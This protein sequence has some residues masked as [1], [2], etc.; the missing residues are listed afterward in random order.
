MPGFVGHLK[1]F[2]FAATAADCPSPGVF[3]GSNL[4]QLWDAGPKL[5]DRLWPAPAA[6][7]ACARARRSYTTCLA[8]HAG[9]D[10]SRF[11]TFAELHGSTDPTSPL[12]APATDAV[13]HRR[14][15][16]TAR[17]GVFPYPTSFGEPFGPSAAQTP[18]PLWPPTTTGT[19]A[20]APS[21]TITYP[22]GVVDAGLGISALTFDDLQIRF[23]AC[24]G[25]NAPAACTFIP[26]PRPSRRCRRAGSARETILALTAGARV[27]RRRTACPDAPSQARSATRRGTGPSPSRPWRP[28]RRSSAAGRRPTRTP[29]NTALPRRHPDTAERPGDRGPATDPVN[30]AS[31]CATRIKRRYGHRAPGE[32][33]ST[34]R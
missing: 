10:A 12:F 16:T 6:G 31:G 30:P 23:G 34:S 20:V 11:Y 27:G 18:V 28:R 26:P 1:A 17:N 14:V 3:L 8:A 21:D 32:P 29:P 22:A 19:G 9:A 25:V 7:P 13:L 5:R 24:L 33:R 2:R 15:F 4:C